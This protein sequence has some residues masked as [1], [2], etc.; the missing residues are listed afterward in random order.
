MIKYFEDRNKKNIKK[1]INT[2]LTTRHI[3]AVGQNQAYLP[4][5]GV[6]RY[7][8]DRFT[9]S[10]DRKFGVNYPTDDACVRK[11]GCRISA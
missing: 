9:A 2:Q 7:T 11:H 8:I 5:I 4:M 3:I 1:K 6:A 10:Y